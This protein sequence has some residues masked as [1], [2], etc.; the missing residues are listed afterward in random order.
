MKAYALY[1]V[2]LKLIVVLQLVL[3]FLKKQSEESSVFIISNVIFKIS[4]ALFLVLFFIFND[5]PGINN[6]DKIIIYY[7]GVFLLY[8]SMFLDIPKVLAKFNIQFNPFL[9]S[10]YF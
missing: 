4:L 10:S 2:F 3:I 1:F 8:D 6:W 7:A 5:I 9:L